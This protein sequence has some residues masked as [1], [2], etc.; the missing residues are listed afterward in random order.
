[1]ALPETVDF[2]AGGVL[3]HH[4]VVGR[5]HF[6]RGYGRRHLDFGMF[7]FL[8]LFFGDHHRFLSEG[9]YCRAKKAGFEFGQGQ[10][11]I[12]Y[13]P[14]RHKKKGDSGRFRIATC[15]SGK[16][17]SDPRHRPWQ[18]R[19]LPLSYSRAYTRLLKQEFPLLWHRKPCERRDLNPHAERH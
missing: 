16:R 1:M 5:A 10:R 6:R 2:H 17:E 9:K 12:N 4:F 11:P 3:F 15:W 18:G 13:I 8:D 19:A 7:K 14:E